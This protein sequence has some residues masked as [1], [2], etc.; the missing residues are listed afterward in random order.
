MARCP[1][2]SGRC[3]RERAPLARTGRGPQPKE[4]RDRREIKQTILASLNLEL[5]CEMRVYDCEG[6]RDRPEQREMLHPASCQTAFHRR[7][8]HSLQRGDVYLGIS[9][10]VS[11][12][13]LV[14]DHHPTNIC[15]PD[16]CSPPNS[17]QPVESGRVWARLGRLHKFRSQR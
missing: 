3:L 1:K 9:R 16:R 10:I 2:N 8:W 11:R 12:S 14:V 13:R 5:T 17:S 15:H 7:R 6:E 4:S